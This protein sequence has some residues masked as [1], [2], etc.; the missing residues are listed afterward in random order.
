MSDLT[1]DERRAILDEEYDLATARQVYLDL[2]HLKTQGM[3]EGGRIPPWA[4]RL[5]RALE[6][7]E[8]SYAVTNTALGK[9]AD[10][11]YKAL[12]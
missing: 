7:S 1:N 5:G 3:W 2:K 12:S 10:A 8:G 4:T 6:A 11:F 9:C